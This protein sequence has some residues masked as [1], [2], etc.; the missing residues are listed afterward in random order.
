[1]YASKIR[2]TNVASNPGARFFDFFL[3]IFFH[4][5]F[6]F[7]R[8]EGIKLDKIRLNL[9]SRADMLQDQQQQLEATGK[10]SREEIEAADWEV[11]K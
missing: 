6:P 3:S 9:L 1:L 2:L 5:L 8:Q 11:V 10:K 4:F 7:N